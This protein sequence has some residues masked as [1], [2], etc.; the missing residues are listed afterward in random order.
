MPRRYTVITP[1]IVDK[2]RKYLAD[3]RGFSKAE[4]AR[5][6]GISDHSVQRIVQGYYDQSVE[7]PKATQAVDSEPQ[8]N[9]HITEIPFEKLEYLMKC[10]MFIEELFSVAVL[11]DK[12]EEELYFPRR[13][14]NSMCTRYFPEKFRETIS[15]LYNDTNA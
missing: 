9:K 11:S 3:D 6:V 7:K 8:G 13:Y 12:A 15:N 14:T 2:V 4:V 1:Q 10:E 5:L